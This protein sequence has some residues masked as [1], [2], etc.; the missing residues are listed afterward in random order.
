MQ[1]ITVRL[2]LRGEDEKCE[3]ITALVDSGFEYPRPML[4]L[5]LA[6][7]LGTIKEYTGGL[8]AVTFNNITAKPRGTITLSCS[9]GTNS[10]DTECHVFD[11]IEQGMIV[12]PEFAR[13]HELPVCQAFSAAP[14]KSK[15]VQ[16][17]QTQGK[18]LSLMV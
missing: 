15:I 4:D 8:S 16:N 18:Y 7:T 9:D 11:K 14:V 13:L 6:Q 10:F 5:S 3:S 12:S 2:A 1:Q 17:K